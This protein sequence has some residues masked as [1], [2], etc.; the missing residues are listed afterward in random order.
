MIARLDS[1][2]RTAIAMT[3]FRDQNEF[4][5]REEFLVPL[6]RCAGYEATGIERTIRDANLSFGTDKV[7]AHVRRHIFPDFVLT[8]NGVGLWVVDAKSPK[9]QVDSPE[10]LAQIESYSRRLD[11]PNVMI[12]NAIETHA[13]LVDESG[14]RQTHLFSKEQVCTD[15]WHELL[16]LLSPA[17]TLSRLISFH[18]ALDLYQTDEYIDR[19]FIIKVLQIYPIADVL[20]LL[21]DHQNWIH[22]S[23]GFRD[24]ALF[25]ILGASHGCEAPGV[26][27]GIIES[28]LND[29]ESVVRE[30]LLT[31]LVTS[32]GMIDADLLPKDLYAIRPST[33]L[34]E[35]VFAGFLGTTDRGRRLLSTYKPVHR[36]LRDYLSCVFSAPGVSFPLALPLSKPR[37]LSF[38]GY[39]QYLMSLPPILR[40]VVEDGRTHP[41]TIKVIESCLS[42]GAAQNRH[43]YEFLLRHATRSEKLV[44]Q[45]FS[46]RKSEFRGHTVRRSCLG[47]GRLLSALGASVKPCGYLSRPEA[48]GQGE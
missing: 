37:V 46:R 23:E 18:Q 28:S 26:L 38:Q 3:D 43:V 35:V 16:S 20:P 11:C 19:S 27:Q 42:F 39:E 7:S 4:F 44:I 13:F 21:E 47:I 14:I 6:F 41:E 15:R 1:E 2:A 40:T 30:N 22:S 8:R 31:C 36:W 24:R 48:I 9:V 34:E 25:A 12:S 32:A 29:R 10:N 45:H 17:S 5:V 33:A